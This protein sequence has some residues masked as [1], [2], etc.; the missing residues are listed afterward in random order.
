MII[1]DDARTR[2]TGAGCGNAIFGPTT[3]AVFEFNKR[4]Y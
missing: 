4:L 3:L 1:H 2:T